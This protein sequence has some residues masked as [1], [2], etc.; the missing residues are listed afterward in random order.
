LSLQQ[1]NKIQLTI[2][3]ENAKN[4]IKDMEIS[5]SSYQASQTWK[6]TLRNISFHP[7]GSKGYKNINSIQAC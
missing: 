7:G 5:Y 2:F 3:Y 1:L 4:E 6:I